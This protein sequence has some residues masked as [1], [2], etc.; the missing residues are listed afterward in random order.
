GDHD[1]RNRRLLMRSTRASWVP[2]VFAS[3]VAGLL[4]WGIHALFP[5]VP[6]LTASVALGI[7]VAQLPGLRPLLTDALAAGLSLASK[8]FMRLGIVLLGL[9]LSVVDIL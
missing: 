3:A 9:K 4:A 8:K 7:I 6:L 5:A 2:G 1:S